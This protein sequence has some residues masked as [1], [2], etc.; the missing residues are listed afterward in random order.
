MT[1]G[2]D[3]ISGINLPQL[4]TDLGFA[5]LAKIQ[6]KDIATDFMPASVAGLADGDLAILHA[7]YT[8]R[9]AE[10]YG[11]SNFSDGQ[12]A[13]AVHRAAIANGMRPGPIYNFQTFASEYFTNPEGP[14]AQEREA[15]TIRIRPDV[16]T[17]D[18]NPLVPARRPQL[19]IDYA[20]CLTGR[21][22]LADQAG[23]LLRGI[24]PFSYSPLMRLH[25][26]NQVLLNTYD[27][28]F[29]AG[30]LQAVVTNQLYIGRE[31]GVTSAT[32]E[33]LRAQSA[34]GARTDVAD[35]VLVTGA[36]HSTR[37][38]LMPGMANA[39][40][41]LREAGMLVIRSLARPAAAEIGTDEIAS[42]AYEAGFEERHAI[43]YEAALHKMGSLLVSGHFG[44]R[45]IQTVVL[46]K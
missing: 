28:L 39:H 14:Y 12:I 36:Q 11:E 2:T 33:I 34:A 40:D 41:L 38:D 26:T 31:D 42:W 16:M 17:I 27:E 15:S 23:F 21:S 20:A 3:E 13:Q 7:E 32:N 1:N 18:D 44:D 10:L 43:R 5:E 4:V 22:Y 45:E 8:G 9:K 25:F 6:V 37:E 24:R 19:V 35:I 30:S 29:G 46:K